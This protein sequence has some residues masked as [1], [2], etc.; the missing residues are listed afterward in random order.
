MSQRKARAFTAVT[1]LAVTVTAWL[2]LGLDGISP[3]ER[4]YLLLPPVIAGGFLVLAP[5]G[6][7]DLRPQLYRA[8]VYFA[9][10]ATLVTAGQVATGFAFRRPGASLFDTVRPGETLFCSYF[11]A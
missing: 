8:A 7:G 10:I 9:C 2:L 5:N 3:S 1:V 11:L 6:W 4:F